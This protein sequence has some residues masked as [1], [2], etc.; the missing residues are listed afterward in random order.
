MYIFFK[1]S[2]PLEKLANMLQILE[3]PKME[4]FAL[5]DTFLKGKKAWPAVP[6]A[7]LEHYTSQNRPS[8]SAMLPNASQRPPVL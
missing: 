5:P 2:E 1:L 3:I 4:R 6:R 8:C 7:P